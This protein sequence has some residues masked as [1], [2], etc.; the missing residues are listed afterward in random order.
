MT[1]LNSVLSSLTTSTVALGL[2]QQELIK[3]GRRL[4]GIWNGNTLNL[5]ITVNIETFYKPDAIIQTLN[6]PIYSN[7]DLGWLSAVTKAKGMQE[8]S[9]VLN[10]NDQKD[11]AIIW[12]LFI[13]CAREV[14][15]CSEYLD[16]LKYIPI[17][18]LPNIAPWTNQDY[19]TVVIKYLV[20]GDFNNAVFTL[21]KYQ[22]KS[23]VQDLCLIIGNFPDRNDY[24]SFRDYIEAWEVWKMRVSSGTFYNFYSL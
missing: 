17:P 7:L 8:I 11:L 6:V 9:T 3:S 12:D 20:H 5:F 19:W 22:D 21:N 4:E 13:I 15:P 1:L 24:A 18:K 14:F 10:E 23:V 2:T 16:W